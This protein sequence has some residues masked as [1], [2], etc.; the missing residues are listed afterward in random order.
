MVGHIRQVTRMARPSKRQQIA[1]AAVEHF[2]SHGYN[3]TGIGD[4]AAAAGAPKG[5]FYNHYDSKTQAAMEAVS[6]Y[7]ESLPLDVLSTPGR[8]P[9]GRL[10]THF[11]L[12]G[13]E[14]IRGGYSRGC[15]VGNFGAEIADH[16]D[17][18][19]SVLKEGVERWTELVRQVLGQAQEAGELDPELD[20]LTLAHSILSAWEGTLIMARITKSA[21]SFDAFYS[22]TFDVLLRRPR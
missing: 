6:R 8:S 17:E 16:S 7:A 21:T 15:M 11:E 22:T 19:R 2:H 9:L 18:I 1:D 13:Q 4:I 10:R 20:A 14:T 3:A 5:S 12:M